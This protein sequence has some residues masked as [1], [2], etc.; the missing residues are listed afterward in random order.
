[1]QERK[2]ISILLIA[3]NKYSQFVQPLIDSIEKYFLLNHD[4]TIHLFTDKLFI[5]KTNRCLFKQYA[6][7]SYG[8]PQAT[9]YRY[10]IFTEHDV[11]LSD[12][13]YIF[14]LD[15]DMQVVSEVGDEILGEGLTAVHHPGFFS[16]GG[17]GSSNCNP[18][19]NAFVHKNKR[20]NYFA[21]G[22]Q[23]GVTSLYLRICRILS[24]RIKED[25]TNGVMAEWHDE[26]HWNWALNDFLNGCGFRKQPPSYCMV[27]DVER[28]KLWGINHFEPKII[29]LNKNHKEVRN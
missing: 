19:S 21:G 9:L 8:F 17:Y 13:D 22:F 7:P 23:G 12:S 16:N 6:I 1:M 28:R 4:V 2:Q 11:F 10:K 3:T 27:E 25:E 29:A 20:Y 14:Y 24:H 18:K 5:A 15:V 26:T